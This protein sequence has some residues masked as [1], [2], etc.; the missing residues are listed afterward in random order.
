[1]HQ[2]MHDIGELLMGPK[3]LPE[4]LIYLNAFSCPVVADEFVMGRHPDTP[5]LVHRD[6]VDAYISK[7]RRCVRGYFA[8]LADVTL[9]SPRWKV[10][11]PY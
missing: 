11:S 7:L 3:S 10:E 1:M 2:A 9:P 5:A 4:L 8:E 6:E